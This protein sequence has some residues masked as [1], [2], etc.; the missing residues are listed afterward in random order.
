L[1]LLLK[2]Y[3]KTYRKLNIYT[4]EHSNIVNSGEFGG[5]KRNNETTSENQTIF[6]IRGQSKFR[7]LQYSNHFLAAFMKEIYALFCCQLFFVV[8]TMFFF[9]CNA[10]KNDNYGKKI[11]CL[12]INN[13]IS[14]IVVRGDIW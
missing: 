3:Q 13:I 10:L 7:K 1:C 6:D 8:F 9:T 2:Q 12:G 5:L 11:I 14:E 4:M